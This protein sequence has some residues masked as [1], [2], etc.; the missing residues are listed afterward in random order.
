VDQHQQSRWRPTRRQILGTVGIVV[1]LVVLIRT[2]YA[3]QWTGSGQTEVKEGVQPSK[4]LWDWLDLLIVPVVLAI[5]GYLFTR[6]E[7][8]AT[9]A[10]A[11][12]RTQDEALQAC[13]AHSIGS[14]CHP[15]SFWE[16]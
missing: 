10:A 12:R 3:Y 7:N 4:T 14:H 9:Q 6:F 16:R 11:E 5:R 15:F 13:L 1:A 8:Q 2:G